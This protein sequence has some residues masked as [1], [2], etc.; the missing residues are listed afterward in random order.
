MQD[1]QTHP[2]R[3]IVWCGF[4]AGGVVGPY[5]FETDD[6]IAVTVN[7]ERYRNMIST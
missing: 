3:T 2:L 6:G 1:R 7:G 4:W 5:F